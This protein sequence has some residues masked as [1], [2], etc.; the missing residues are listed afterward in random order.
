M[1]ENIHETCSCQSP[2]Y[3]LTLLCTKHNISSNR[4]HHSQPS[5][6]LGNIQGDYDLTVHILD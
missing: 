4:D 2:H 1:Y 6:T 3:Y 5:Q